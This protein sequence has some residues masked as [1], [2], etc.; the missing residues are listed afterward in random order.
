ML[1]TI[2]SRIMRY[3]N[4]RNLM[5][6]EEM[7]SLDLDLRPH[8]EDLINAVSYNPYDPYNIWQAHFDMIRQRVY[9]NNQ[10]YLAIFTGPTG[11]GKSY[12]SLAFALT[13][14]PDFNIEERIV[15]NVKDFFRLINSGELKK[16][17]VIIWEELGTS[18]PSEEWY[19]KQNKAVRM[20]LETFRTDNLIVI[21]NV[22]YLKFIDS[23]IRMLM[24]AHYKAMGFNKKRGLGYVKPYAIDYNEYMDKIFYPTMK[25]KVMGKIVKIKY[26][27][28][29]RIPNKIAKRYEKVREDFLEELKLR[30][31]TEI[32]VEEIKD[33][34][35]DVQYKKLIVREIE[36]LRAE[37]YK[38]REIAEYMLEEYNINKKE[39]SWQYF[40]KQNKEKFF[41]P[42][43]EELIEQIKNSK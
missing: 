3:P 28:I 9:E 24:H 11:S 38:W 20:V 35:R 43:F 29:P 1:E 26:L 7:I 25:L 15:F 14:N 5:N 17:D 42:K 21:F 36:R 31:E 16:G 40:Y 39:A 41:K 27:K 12:S 8:Y 13:L 37:G 18:T 33:E 10:N 6:L 34:N 19:S 4:K 2:Q 30:H 23:K 22:P 32:R